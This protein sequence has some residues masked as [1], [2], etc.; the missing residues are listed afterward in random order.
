M[1]HAGTTLTFS[2]GLLFGLPAFEVWY[3]RPALSSCW[4]RIRCLQASLL[5]ALQ[6]RWPMTLVSDEWGSRTSE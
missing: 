3:R 5:A 2:I 4:R 1:R 6:Y